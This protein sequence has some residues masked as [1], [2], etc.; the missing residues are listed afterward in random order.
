MPPSEKFSLRRRLRSFRFAYSGILLM[1][2][3]Q[4]NA[5]IH[6]LAA[7]VASI[8]G[9]VTGLSTSEWLWIVVVIGMVFTAEAFNTSIEYLTNILSPDYNIKVG[10]AKDLAAA[11]VLLTTIAAVIVGLLIFVPKFI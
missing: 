8:L 10:K 1:F 7:T 11:A 9:Y 2:K 3:S 5:W 4:H 6:L